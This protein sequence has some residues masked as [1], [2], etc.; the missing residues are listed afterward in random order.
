MEITSCNVEKIKILFRCSSKIDFKSVKVAR[1]TAWIAYYKKYVALKIYAIYTF[2]SRI[3]IEELIPVIFL[4]IILL[5][6]LS[7]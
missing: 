5:R 6:S 2:L 3:F 1:V 4:T 7:Y